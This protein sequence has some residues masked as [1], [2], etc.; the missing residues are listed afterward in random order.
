MIDVVDKETLSSKEENQKIVPLDVMLATN[1]VIFLKNHDGDDDDNE[2]GDS[3]NKNVE[4]MLIFIR[5]LDMGSKLDVLRIQ[6]TFM[7]FLIVNS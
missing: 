5:E 3:S 2:N 7:R 6:Q 4:D 1:N